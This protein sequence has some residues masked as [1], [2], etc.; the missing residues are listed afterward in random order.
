M[1]GGAGQ[2]VLVG[3]SGRDVMNGGSGADTFVFLSA[4]D[5]GTNRHRDIIQDF[6]T[7]ADKIDLQAVFEGRESDALTWRG[8]GAFGGTEGEIRTRETANGTLVMVDLDGNGRS[9]M[10]LLVCGDHQLAASDF[11]L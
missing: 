6:Q 4:G 3:G 1:Y 8:T 11:L 10:D 2:D 7:G 5:S 9:D